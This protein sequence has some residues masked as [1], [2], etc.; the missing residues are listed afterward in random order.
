M[1]NIFEHDIYSITQGSWIS[2]DGFWVDSL[3]SN[4]APC[5]EDWLNENDFPLIDC[6]EDVDFMSDT[7]SIDPIDL[8]EPEDFGC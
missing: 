7:E 2:E 3:T 8:S 5:P 6:D 1:D 4:V